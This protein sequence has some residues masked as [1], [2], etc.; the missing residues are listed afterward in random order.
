MIKY[1]VIIIFIFYACSNPKPVVKKKNKID[2]EKIE[3]QKKNNTAK[4]LWENRSDLDTLRKSI[5]L[6]EEILPDLKENDK[7]DVKLYLAEAYYLLSMLD[8]KKRKNN[9]IKSIN[10]SYE[11]LLEKSQKY[12]EE[13]DR[14]IQDYMA[15]N[16]IPNNM[17]WVLNLY[18]ISNLMLRIE[19]NSL[20][21][22]RDDILSCLDH[23]KSISPE[24]LY[25]D[26]LSYEGYFYYFLPKIGGGS[27]EKSKSILDNSKNKSF[28]AKIIYT[29][30]FES[31]K[32]KL[33]NLLTKSKNKNHKV[34]IKY[35]LTN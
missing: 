9:L 22:Y 33:R 21:L 26:I 13:K 10:Y 34:L 1:I 31:D 14:L 32:E 18:T 28:I 4:L 23:L 3:L 6:W 7:I 12:K 5:K 11:V 2:R 27:F 17:F 29:K 24:D 35:F 25:H 15:I 19:E 20:L 30:L 8:I 16:K